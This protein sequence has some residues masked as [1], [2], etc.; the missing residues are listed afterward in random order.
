MM[1][2]HFKLYEVNVFKSYCPTKSIM[3]PFV[4]D[5]LEIF[6]VFLIWLTAVIAIFFCTL[7]LAGAI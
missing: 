2:P 6:A 5:I 4:L 3:R 7:F 1:I